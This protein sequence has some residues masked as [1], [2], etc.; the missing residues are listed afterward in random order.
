LV[1]ETLYSSLLVLAA[2]DQPVTRTQKANPKGRESP[3]VKLEGKSPFG[4]AEPSHNFR[5]EIKKKLIELVRFVQVRPVT[6]L[7]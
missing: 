6:R 5:K 7:L 3:G 1:T 4:E 2:P